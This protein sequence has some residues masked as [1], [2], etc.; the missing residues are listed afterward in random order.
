MTQPAYTQSEWESLAPW[1][2]AAQWREVAPQIADEVML[3]AKQQATHRWTIELA[4][5]E[6]RRRMEVRVW[7][8]QICGYVL[9]LLSVLM[10]SAVAWHYADKGHFLPGLAALGAGSIGTGAVFATGYAMARHYT[11]RRRR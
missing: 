5:A 10:L 4:D 2:K 11:E 6:H 1:E 9:N 8:T 3:L 7:A